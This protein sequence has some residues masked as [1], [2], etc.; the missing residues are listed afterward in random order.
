MERIFLVGYMGAGKTTV[1][2]M[3]ARQ[4]GLSFVD[5]DKYIEGRYCKSIAV[6]FEEK[7]EEEFREIE[8]RMLAEV[9]TFEDV[10][11]STGGGT[12]CY[13]NNMEEMKK[14]GTTV[15]LRASVEDLAVR[16]E[17]SSHVRPLVQGL[18]GDE[19]RTFIRRGLAEREAFYN[20]AE[21]VWDA[22][23]TGAPVTGGLLTPP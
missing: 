11:I 19:L 4:K 16:I 7:G 5:L 22:P 15:Y 23:V 12:P 9:S 18:T 2:R 14:R 8:R 1:G 6:L 3:L 10:V 17:K 13:H 20:Q 21:V